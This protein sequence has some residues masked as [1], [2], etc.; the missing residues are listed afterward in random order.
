MPVA[1]T[2]A[3]SDSGGGAGIQADL[4]TF[5]ALGAFGTTAITCLTAQN[6]N[7]VS[8]VEALPATFV[9]AQ[10]EQLAAYFRIRAL[11]T[12]MLFNA[13]IIGAVCDF[14]RAHRDI[15][16]VVD[17]VMVATSGAVLLRQDA[18]EAIAR[19]LIPLATLVTPNLDEAG[20]LL[21]RKVTDVAAMR[22]AA[23]ELSARTGANVLLKGG[24]LADG[25]VVDLLCTRD[26]EL[27]EFRH[28]RVRGVNTHGSGCTLSAA[29]CAELAKGV[30]LDKAVSNAL[31][32]LM[33]TLREALTVSGERFI[34]HLPGR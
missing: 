3:G 10:L 13:G 26:G 21:G 11:K 28:E 4:L 23:R 1:L 17:P 27:A 14:L 15:Q 34:A 16:V 22:Q 20:V 9:S 24:H 30:V 33:R 32:Y 18:V 2:A 19:D 5:A 8:A 25:P 12:G 7:G 31:D 29:I 6:P